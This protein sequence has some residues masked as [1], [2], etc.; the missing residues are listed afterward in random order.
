MEKIEGAGE[1]AVERAAD[2]VGPRLDR[3]ALAPRGGGEEIDDALVEVEDDDPLRPADERERQAH[4][5]E[6]ADH[7]HVRSVEV[8]TLAQERG[9][10]PA[11]FGGDGSLIAIEAWRRPSL[12]Q[13]LESGELTRTSADGI[14]APVAGGTARV[15]GRAAAARSRETGG[16]RSD[17]PLLDR[18][19]PIGAERRRGSVELG[20]RAVL[21]VG[22]DAPRGTRGAEEAF[23]DLRLDPVP[24]VRAH[25]AS[26]ST[27]RAERTRRGGR[28]ACSGGQRTRDRVRRSTW[29]T[30]NRGRMRS[31][32]PDREES[33]CGSIPRRQTASGSGRRRR[34]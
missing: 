15:E 17:E 4:H 19:E 20:E 34:C 18:D 21:C 29:A 6:V 28:R 10:E 1:I 26:S 8:A 32:L 31:N 23:E 11:V 2:V 9:A 24:R 33:A 27:K 13:A 30:S 16:R 12:E 3:Q 22:D 14:A 7:E 5:V 25:R